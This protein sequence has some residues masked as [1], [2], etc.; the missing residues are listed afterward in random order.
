[1]VLALFSWPLFSFSAD[2]FTPETSHPK[3]FVHGIFLESHRN[4]GGDFDA[5]VVSKRV[6]LILKML[7]FPHF[8]LAH[9]IHQ[10][11]V[12]FLSTPNVHLID[13]FFCI[14]TKGVLLFF[15]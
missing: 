3:T 7:I 9:H 8:I 11:Y 13:L 1:V 6:S 5:F 12:F 4:W 2:L 10:N 15:L 14:L